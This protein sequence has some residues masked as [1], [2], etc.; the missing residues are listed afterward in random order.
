MMMI[1]T[2]DWFEREERYLDE[3]DGLKFLEEEEQQMDDR[4]CVLNWI[5]KFRRFLERVWRS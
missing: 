1:R 2:A 5:G 4:V 3:L